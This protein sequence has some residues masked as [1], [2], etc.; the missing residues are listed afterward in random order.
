MRYHSRC[1]GDAAGLRACLGVVW[2]ILLAAAAGRLHQSG[3]RKPSHTSLV[4]PP[5]TR[6]AAS[7]LLPP[8]TSASAHR[9]RVPARPPSS[10]C[11]LRPLS[12][13]PAIAVAEAV[14]VR[15]SL[16]AAP[17]RSDEHLCPPPISCRL[18]HA[19]RDHD[20]DSPGHHHARPCILNSAAAISQGPPAIVAHHGSEQRQ[21]R[22]LY[23]PRCVPYPAAM[24]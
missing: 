5:P 8:F 17:A 2:R 22:R 11:C 24:V 18:L 16:L 23:R 20:H 15:C 9:P 14:P 21:A 4:E 6:R 19:A 10:S 1:T 12:A 13:V 3:P 7:K